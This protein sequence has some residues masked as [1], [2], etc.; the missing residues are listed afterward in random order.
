M[1]VPHGLSGGDDELFSKSQCASKSGGEQLRLVKV[2]EDEDV[3]L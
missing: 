2:S 1:L 3:F